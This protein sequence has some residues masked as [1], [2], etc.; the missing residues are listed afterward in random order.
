ML[1][2]KT[3]LL[4]SILFSLLALIGCGTKTTTEDALDYDDFDYLSDYDEVFDRPVGTYL[5][6]VYAET[7]QACARLKTDILAFAS[8][9]TDHVIYFFNAGAVDSTNQAPYLE[10]IG[11]ASVQ[12]PT[13]LVIKDGFDL[14]NVSRYL[15]IGE[16]RIRSLIT[17]LTNDAYPY[18]N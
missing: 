15:F 10:A 17:D 14:T 12:T 1:L 13:M 6:Y 7:C 4:F 8:Q 2:K 11:Q 9:Y 3:I 5:V 18:W 16:T